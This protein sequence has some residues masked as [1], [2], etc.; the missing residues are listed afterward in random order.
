VTTEDDFQAA[1]DAHP[2]DWQTRL[3]FA[4]WLDERGDPRAEGYRALGTL[5]LCPDYCAQ[6]LKKPWSWIEL[7]AGKPYT[8]TYPTR[9]KADDDAALTFVRLAPH[10]KR[11]YLKL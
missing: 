3:V 11:R 7:D 5:S 8:A 9:R 4:D 1:L 6:A 10:T 2:K